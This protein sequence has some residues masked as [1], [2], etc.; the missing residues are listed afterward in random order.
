MAKYLIKVG[1]VGILTFLVLFIYFYKTYVKFRQSMNCAFVVTTVY[2]SGL[3]PAH[4]ISQLDGAFT[5][6]NQQHQSRPHR[7]WS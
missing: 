3:T 1:F 7:G 6:Q 2:F 5:K 4:S